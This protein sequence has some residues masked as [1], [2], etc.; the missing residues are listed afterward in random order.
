[1]LEEWS[2]TDNI[3]EAVNPSL[4]RFGWALGCL[5]CSG[6]AHHADLCHGCCHLGVAHQDRLQIT[7]RHDKSIRKA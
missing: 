4:V 3:G 7:C 5:G 2:L 1:M 6:Q